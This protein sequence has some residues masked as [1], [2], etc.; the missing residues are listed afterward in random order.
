MPTKTMDNNDNDKDMSHSTPV[1]IDFNDLTC[2]DY[3]E[4]LQETIEQAFSLNGFGAIIIT[5]IPDFKET[6]KK[7]LENIYQL[8]KEPQQVLDALCQSNTDSLYEVGWHIKKMNAAFGKSSNKFVSFFSR[9]PQESVIFPLDPQFEKENIN[10]WPVTVPQYK[11][12][13]SNLNKLLVPPLLGLLK[14]F[15]KYLSRNISDYP[16]NK[17]VESFT[18]HYTCHN[19]VIVYSPLDECGSG[20]DDKYNWDNWH[21][22]FGLMAT[23]THPMY[24]TKEGDIYDLDKTAFYLRD[25]H[26]REHEAVFSEDEFMITAGDAMFIESAGYIPATPHTVKIVSGMP[27]NV[28]RAQSVSFF[29]P[30]LNYKMNIPSQE[31]FRQIINRDPCKYDHRGID[32]FKD[33]CY[34]KAFLDDLLEFLY[35]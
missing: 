33:G 7:V 16:Q 35:K 4:D 22:D 24:L 12:D 25:R 21:T 20:E 19:R 8:S 31:S 32:S 29:E 11:Q 17:F 15:D 10:M 34:Y 27:D 13:L 30:Y 9:Y 3:N 1:R 23:A 2:D 5:N 28:C 6:R 14:Y 26:G 18:N